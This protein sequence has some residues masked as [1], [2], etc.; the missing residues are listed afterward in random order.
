MGGCTF[1]NE[2]E[3]KTAK[4]AFTRAVEDAQY[5]SGHG[6]YT[7][8]IAE[9]HSF[10][11]IDAEAE[12]ARVEKGLREKL[13]R[14]TLAEQKKLVRRYEELRAKRE[15]SFASLTE[16]ENEEFFMLPSQVPDAAQLAERKA[17][18]RE[19][20]KTVRKVR[21]RAIVIARFLIDARDSRVDEKWGPAGCIKLPGGKWLFFGWASS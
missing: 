9:K 10:V 13:S 3:G 15:K 5:E 20:I 21:A 8:T 4:A 16:A 6:G 17:R 12:A 11:M 19:E 2:V 18:V 14:F 7:G 1:Y